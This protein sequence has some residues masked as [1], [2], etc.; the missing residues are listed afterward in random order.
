MSSTKYF[1]FALLICLLAVSAAC[2]RIKS[3]NPLSPD[4]AGPI[5]GVNIT[6]P[7][8]LAPAPG[9]EI[10]ADGSATTTLMLENPTT[11]SQRPYWLQIEL[12]SDAN[13]QQ[14]LHQADRVT[15]GPNGRTE[16]TIPQPLGAGHTYHWR[17]RA[18][19]GANTGPYSGA[20]NFRTVELVVLEAPIPLEPQGTLTTNRPQF[21]ARNGRIS[22]TTGE[23]H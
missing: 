7:R 5:P 21:R 17:A 16:Y 3:A 13:F 20:F 8:L 12:A 9:T 10:T 19:D 2:E 14:V 4:V 22:G 23:V 15:P 18:L 11:N 1:Q 6:A